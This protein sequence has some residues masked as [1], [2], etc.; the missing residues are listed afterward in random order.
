MAEAAAA[1]APAGPAAAAPAAAPVAPGADAPA[2]PQSGKGDDGAAPAAPR[3]L[4]PIPSLPGVFPDDDPFPASAPQ[5]PDSPSTS[6]GDRPR[7]PDG[8]FVAA[9]SPPVAGEPASDRRD[10]GPAP[11][12]AKF[13]IAGEEFESQEAFE[14]NYKSLRGNFKP[15]LGLAKHLGGV[16]KIAPHL[17]Q[18]TESARAW[19]AEADRLRAELDGR[20]AQPA[21]PVA[22]KPNAASPTAPDGKPATEA[23]S[24]D[25]GLYA[26]VKKLANQSGEPWKAEQWLI[27]Q[28]R[29]GERARVEKM[30]DER[31]APITDAQSKLRAAAKTEALFENLAQYTLDDGS[32]AFPEL[33][34]EV[35]AREIGRLW[36]SLG[37]PPEAAMTPQ[38]AIAAI[39]TYRMRARPQ[40]SP[41][42]APA[43]RTL[44]PAPGPADTHAAADMGDGKPMLM[45]AGDG[46]TPSAEAARIIAGLRAVNQG[47]R[48]HL[49]FEP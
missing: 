2:P 4:R 27:E 6:S 14:Q 42:P 10:P 24:V 35:A 45:S 25:W 21:T 38:G 48:T 11:Q 36:V 16:D 23:D 13:K 7:G 17:T 9:S 28:V 46:A 15:L 22:A 41:A 49:G 44:P 39:A 20:T 29:K 34:D 40:A 32:P 5:Q 26:E 31:F 18:A 8:R 30:L 3:T 12:P 33:S 47:S 19:K 43:P 1:P 37:L